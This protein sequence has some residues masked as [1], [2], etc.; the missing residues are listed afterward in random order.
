M[1]RKKVESFRK[2]IRTLDILFD[3]Y[4]KELTS[5]Y[6]IPLGQFHIL[7]A[8][9]EMEPCSM[10]QLASSLSLEKSKVSRYIDKGF[11]D[12]ANNHSAILNTV[13]IDLYGSGFGFLV[14]SERPN[15]SGYENSEKLMYQLAYSNSLFEDEVYQTNYTVGWR[16]F[17]FPDEPRKACDAQEILG[18]FS[19]PKLFDNGIV[20]SYTVIAR[21]PSESDSGAC[22]SSGWVHILGLGCDV[23]LPEF[24]CETHGHPFHLCAELWFNDGLGGGGVDHDWS[25]AMFGIS[26]DFELAEHF[27]LTPGLYY[28]VSMDDSVNKSDEKWVGVGLT[29]KF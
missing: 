28:Q 5:N 25:H 26:T 14:C 12:Y 13:S 1:D 10:V 7:F 27:V 22:E 9:D 15:S 18:G 21:W 3:S 20:P 19:W 11:D 2:N 6:G 24:W 29:Y 16:Y 17:N 4:E 23:C 8:I